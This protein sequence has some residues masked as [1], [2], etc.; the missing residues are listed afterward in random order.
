VSR[1][2]ASVSLAAAC[3]AALACLV[4]P[5]GAG[6][7]SD[8]EVSIMDDQLL[9]DA[10]DAKLEE[11]V[12]RFE[13]LGVDRVR[14]SAFW[15]SHAPQARSRRKPGKFNAASGVDPAYNWVAL[16]RIVGAVTAHNMRLL[17]SITT[18]APLWGTQAP[19]KGNGL[20]KP[21]PKEFANYA[22]AVAQR[23][24]RFPVQYAILNE[25]NQ[26]GWL[27]PQSQGGKLV[28]PR[29]YRNLVRAAYPRIK[30]RDPSSIVLVGELAPSGRDKRGEREPIRPLEFLRAFGS[31]SSPPPADAIGHHPY[32]FFDPPTQRSEDPD[33]AAIGDASRLLA[34]LDKLTSKGAI[35]A[36]R[37]SKL[38]VYYTEFGYQ[39]DPPDPFA[40]I[41]LS[42]QDRYLQEAAY[43][44]W[45]NK[46]IKAYNQFR[47]T[48]GKIGR[49]Q[50]L[51]AFN[52][53]QSGLMF[54]NGRKKPS[55]EGFATPLVIDPA[56]PRAG[57]SVRLW[58][59]ARP[60]G[61]HAI[62][63][64][65]R[66]G[67]SGAFERVAQPQTDARGY[68]TTKVNARAGYYRYSYSGGGTSGTSPALRLRT[69]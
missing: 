44:A 7:A 41:S 56:T 17:I 40:G 46:R 43:R 14:V 50:G 2:R 33:D 32:S 63:V 28:A 22:E 67:D 12:T 48:D 57:S 61:A 68:F 10:S 39:T 4:A 51:R 8:T 9:L 5:A 20:Y 69:R 54:A 15:A 53:F 60:G 52:E 37:G 31:T 29:I 64:E 34:T 49:S 36:K 1:P 42:R 25:P 23:Y 66:T 13:R 58:G 11:V 27:Q 24:E 47:L 26:P 35:D 6:A 19:D 38:N 62:T 45:R 65:F 21:D 16:D 59:Q 18:P 3:A 30:Q 55:Y